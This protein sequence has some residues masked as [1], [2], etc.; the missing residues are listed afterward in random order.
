MQRSSCLERFEVS[1][2]ASMASGVQ[3]LD[4]KENFQPFIG[5]VRVEEWGSKGSSMSALIWLGYQFQEGLRNTKIISGIL[6]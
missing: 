2:E 1:V 4:L 6:Q 3:G 5:L